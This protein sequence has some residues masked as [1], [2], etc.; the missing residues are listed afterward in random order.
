M[1]AATVRMTGVL[2]NTTSVLLLPVRKHFLPHI[3][4]QFVCI[5]SYII[6]LHLQDK[7]LFQK[8]KKH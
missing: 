5:Y 7:A 1:A 4:L 3:N 8:K 6:A 2:R